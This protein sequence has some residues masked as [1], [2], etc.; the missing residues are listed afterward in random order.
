[1]RSSTVLIRRKTE[2]GTI[3]Q[4]SPLPHL[5]E[6]DLFTNCHHPITSVFTAGAVAGNPDNDF[7]QFLCRLLNVSKSL[8]TSLVFHSQMKSSDSVVVRFWSTKWP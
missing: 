6:L 5:N 1:M 7:S 8:A 3:G 2:S 4:G